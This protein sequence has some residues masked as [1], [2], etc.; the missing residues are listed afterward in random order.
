[1]AFWTKIIGGKPMPLTSRPNWRDDNGNPVADS[2]LLAEDYRPVEMQ[3]PKHDPAK[4][5]LQQLPMSQWIVQADKVLVPHEV[6][7]YTTDELSGMAR[8]QRNILLQ[9]TDWTQVLDT[10]VDRN[11]WANYRQALR[12]LPEQAGF[13]HN[14]IWPTAPQ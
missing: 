4:Q 5:R 6:I 2:V 8:G 3:Y 1:M 14:I 10:Q 7:N 12:D 11:A 13:P 9:Q